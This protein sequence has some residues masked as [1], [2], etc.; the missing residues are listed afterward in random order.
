[1]EDGRIIAGG[2]PSGLI[3]EHVSPQVLEFR[4]N[5]DALRELRPLLDREAYNVEESGS[6]EALLAFTSD[7]DALM[8]TVRRSGIEVENTV[9]R[10]SGL[11][12]VFLRLTGRSL[13]D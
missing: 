9:Y 3:S 10:Q 12:D 1:M 5:R 2:T 8:E 11:E 6:G 7:A 13:T 4:S